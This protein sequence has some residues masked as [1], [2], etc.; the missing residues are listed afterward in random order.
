[1]SIKLGDKCNAWNVFIHETI[2]NEVPDRDI[3]FFADGD[4][5]ILPGSLTA[6]A[7]GL[8]R[9]PR[10]HAASAPPASGRN[11]KHDR[12]ILLEERHL[13]ANLYALRGSFVKDLQASKI[14]LP[15]GLEGDDGLL[16]ALVKWDLD[17][18]HRG[19]DHLRIEPCP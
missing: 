9:N 4:A 5:R 19:F 12:R 18:A 7:E 2:P 16:G 3:Y 1:M 13:V 10:A 17:P 11:M 14:R 6:L 15:I 8:A